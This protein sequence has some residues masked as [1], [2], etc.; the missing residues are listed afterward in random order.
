MGLGYGNPQAI[1]ALKAGETVL[2][3]GAEGGFDCFLA[4]ETGRSRR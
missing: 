1:A 4:K 3:L 2:D